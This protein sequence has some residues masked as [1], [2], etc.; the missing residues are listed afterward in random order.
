MET[1]ERWQEIEYPHYMTKAEEPLTCFVSDRGRVRLPQRF[2][3]G[4]GGTMRVQKERMAKLYKPQKKYGYVRCCA[5]LVHRLVAHAFVE[6]PE[7]WEDSKLWTVNHIDGDKQNNH[8]TNLEWVTHKENCLKY[9]DSDKAIGK[10][11]KPVIVHRKEDDSYVGVYPSCTHLS[12]ELGLHKSAI[13]MI[14]GG[15]IKTTG[16][17]KVKEITPKEYHAL[18]KTHTSN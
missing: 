15:R 11:N 13:T 8:W 14:L 1:K 4:K 5:G 2:I 17:Y 12:K 18:S 7:G 3:K 16:G 9:Y 10:R 6:K